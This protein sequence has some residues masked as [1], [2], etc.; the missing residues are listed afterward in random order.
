[1]DCYSLSRL[2]LR[3]ATAELAVLSSQ[4]TARLP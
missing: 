3:V 1:M 4:V 2:N